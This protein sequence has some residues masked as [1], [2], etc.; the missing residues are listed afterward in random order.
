MSSRVDVWDVAKTSSQQPLDCGFRRGLLEKY[1]LGRALGEGGFG[2]VRVARSKATGAEFA[3]KTIPKRLDV[4]NLPPAKQVQHLDNIRREV[5]IL[6]KL[7]GTL[8]VSAACVVLKEKKSCGVGCCDVVVCLTLAQSST[9]MQRV[10]QFPGRWRWLW[11]AGTCWGWKRPGNTLGE[12]LGDTGGTGD[13]LGGN[14][15]GTPAF[16]PL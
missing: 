13:I 12:A 14:L 11:L 4:P 9:C 1:D 3:C 6:R 10:S 5:A 8:N 7:R 15:G 2:A 16:V